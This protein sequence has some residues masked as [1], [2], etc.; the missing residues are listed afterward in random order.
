LEVS[1]LSRNALIFFIGDRII[2]LKDYGS[3]P[4]GTKGTIV[5]INGKFLDILFDTFTLI[6]HRKLIDQ[7]SVINLTKH[8]HISLRTSE[9]NIPRKLNYKKIGKRGPVEKRN[10]KKSTFNQR[11]SQSKNKR[12]RNDTDNG[13]NQMRSPR[14]PENKSPRKPENKSPR[15]PE[16]TSPRNPNVR[17]RKNK[18]QKL[19][20]KEK[21]KR[22]RTHS[23][24]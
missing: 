10:I 5:G 9:T 24:L 8:E 21:K 7:G 16:N 17:N 12:T 11:R 6:N 4:F 1:N 19:T 3:I 15:K 14:K 20:Y 18:K 13:G 2:Y 23:T 22:A